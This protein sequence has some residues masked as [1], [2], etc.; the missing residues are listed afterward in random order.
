MNNLE[1]FLERTKA[2]RAR[3]CGIE[4]KSVAHAAKKEAEMARRREEF[5]A[6]LKAAAPVT[7]RPDDPS[8][9]APEL[10]EYKPGHSSSIP[11]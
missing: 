4:R 2:E 10:R 3:L 1:A 5:F 9:D 6:R 8:S 11:F 7:V